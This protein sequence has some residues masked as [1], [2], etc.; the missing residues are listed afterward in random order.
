MKLIDHIT[1]TC[2]TCCH[3]Y[4]HDMFSDAN[5]F[6]VIRTF[7]YIYICIACLVEILNIMENTNEN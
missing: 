5:V 7:T 6:G 2:F 1:F 4:G 3:N